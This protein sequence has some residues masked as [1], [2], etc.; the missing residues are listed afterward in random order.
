M[1][2]GQGRVERTQQVT[3][4]RAQRCFQPF[5]CV[6]RTHKN[7]DVANS[8]LI[9][10]HTD[11][12]RQSFRAFKSSVRFSVSGFQECSMMSARE[13]YTSQSL[14]RLDV[15]PRWRNYTRV[16]P[17]IRNKSC[18]RLHPDQSASTDEGATRSLLGTS[19]DDV[20]RE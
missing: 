11:T 9:P 5:S 8:V 10:S 3:A 7:C 18:V 6:L 2:H 4:R 12:S 19:Q 17:S 14:H 13:T 16:K 1:T 15:A 20:H